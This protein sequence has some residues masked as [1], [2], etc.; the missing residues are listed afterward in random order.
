[1]QLATTID[2][3]D[4]ASN[5]V[6]HFPVIQQFL[7]FGLQHNLIAYL[8]AQPIRRLIRVF[9]TFRLASVQ[10]LM[11][12]WILSSLFLIPELPLIQLPLCK[13]FME[14]LFH[15][16]KCMSFLQDIPCQCL[17]VWI[18]GKDVVGLVVKGL[19]SLNLTLLL[20][21][22]MC[23]RQGFSLSVCQAVAVAAQAST[24]KVYQ[25]YLKE[26]AGMCT[27]EGVSNSVISASKLLMLYF[28][29]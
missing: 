7:D 17:I 25:Q 18:L 9:L 27:Y 22:D 19:P 3:K 28:I 1:M 14:G 23:C 6:H 10:L 16:Q 8:W 12:L 21:R 29:Y 15:I 11:I 5:L 26:W 2:R 4:P 20:L 24:A 13:V